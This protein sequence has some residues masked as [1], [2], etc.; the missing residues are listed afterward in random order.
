MVSIFERE[1]DA[2]REQFVH[3]LMLAYLWENLKKNVPIYPSIKDLYRLY[4][5]YIDDIFIIWTGTKNNSINF[6]L[7]LIIFIIQ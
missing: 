6:S 4:L 5:R 2:P 3:P 7:P 1:K